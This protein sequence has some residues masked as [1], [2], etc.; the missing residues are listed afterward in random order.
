[1]EAHSPPPSSR[2]AGLRR[3]GGR[4]DSR[5]YLL[6]ARGGAL[7]PPCGT[8]GETGR[9]VVGTCS[10]ARRSVS[11]PKRVPSPASVRRLSARGHRHISRVRV[12][13]RS[14]ADDCCPPELQLPGSPGLTVLLIIRP[15][16]FSVNAKIYIYAITLQRPP[17]PC[18]AYLCNASAGLNWRDRHVDLGIGHLIRSLRLEN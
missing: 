7:V 18:H 6:A 14:R 10:A 5:R 17:I 3:A 4:S 8:S 16:S 9:K 15:H 2:L 12:S 13:K 1:M 11:H